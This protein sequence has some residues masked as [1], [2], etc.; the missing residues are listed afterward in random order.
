M[1]EDSGGG[2]GVQRRRLIVLSMALVPVICV[3]ETLAGPLYS[4]NRTAGLDGPL[5]RG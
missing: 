1:A 2:G 4:G 5:W 3:T